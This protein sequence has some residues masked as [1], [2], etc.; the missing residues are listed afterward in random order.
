MLEKGKVLAYQSEVGLFGSYLIRNVTNG[1]AHLRSQH[2]ILM[3]KKKKKKKK[4]RGFHCR[5]KRG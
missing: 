4:E 2:C 1:A 5:L 3:G